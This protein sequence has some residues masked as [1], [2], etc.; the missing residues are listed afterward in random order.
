[1]AKETKTVQCYPDDSKINAEIKRY[2]AFGW[3]LINNQRCQEYEG[4]YDGYK[5]WSTF[6]KL[7]F[8]RDKGASWYGEVTALERDYEN[9]ET[10]CKRY[11]YLKPSEPNN[12]T[13]IFGVFLTLFALI[14]MAGG[15][16]NILLAFMEIGYDL[17]LYLGLIFIALGIM[18]FVGRALIK[19]SKKKKYDV[20]YAEWSSTYN[21]KISAAEKEMNGIMEKAEALINDRNA[22]VFC[23][24][25]G[26]K[27]KAGNAFCSECGGSLRK[28]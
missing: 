25:C 22:E 20:A 12:D 16:L 15:V 4:S 13:T 6:N 1:M 11:K 7:T 19:K 5:H 24:Q 27:N 3:E 21:P 28:L 2:E 9:K 18:R 14:V 8:Q 26:T 10:E 17:G 23:T